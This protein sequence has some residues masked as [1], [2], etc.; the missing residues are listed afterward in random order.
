M[1]ILSNLWHGIQNVRVTIMWRFAIF[2]AFLVIMSIC[3]VAVPVRQEL[4]QN[5]R[6]DA[7][8]DLQKLAKTAADRI[9]TNL[10]NRIKALNGTAT[11]MEF[12]GNDGDPRHM[13]FFKSYAE[14][15]DYIALG[16][17]DKTGKVVAYTTGEPATDLSSRSYIQS[18]LSGKAECSDF[19]TS[20]VTGKF[21]LMIAVPHK[22]GGALI[23][24]VPYEKIYEMVEKIYNYGEGSN[25]FMTNL[26]GVIVAHTDKSLM[27]DGDK[28]T[29][30]SDI[31]H[32]EQDVTSSF[33]SSISKEEGQTFLKGTFNGVTKYYAVARV[34]GKNLTVCVAVTEA[35]LLTSVQSMTRNFI[36]W[37]SIALLVGVL[38]SL[39]AG[40]I[41][42][43]GPK[44]LVEYVKIVMTGKL[45]NNIGKYSNDEI[46]DLA[47]MLN[48]QSRRRM[49][50]IQRLRDLAERHELGYLAERLD[51]EGLQYHILDQSKSVNNLIDSSQK[52][53]QA[54]PVPVLVR[55]PYLTPEE[56]KQSGFKSREVR[57]LN[58]A[59]LLGRVLA[60]VLKKPCSDHFGTEDCLGMC[61]CD[62]A[63]MGQNIRTGS[64]IARPTCLQKPGQPVELNIDYTPNILSIG[65]DGKRVVIEVVKDLTKE[66]GIMKK[67]ADIAVH[68]DTLSIRLG[69][70]SEEL[71]AQADQVL[72]GAG[73]QTAQIQGIATAM[74]QMNTTVFEVAKNASEAAEGA[75]KTKDKAHAGQ[76]CVNEVISSMGDVEGRVGDLRKSM[77]EL[78]ISASAIGKI[79]NT[80]SDIADQTNLLALNAAIEAA[81]AG[82][83]GRGFAVVADEVRKLAEKTMQ[84]TKEVGP[85]IGSIQGGTRLCVENTEK[86]AGAVAKA[87]SF[88]NNAGTSLAEIVDLVD[89]NADQVRN[90]AAAA[91]EQSAASEEI[92]KGV[93]DIN[94][95]SSE[96]TQA[97]N[98]TTQAIGNLARMASELVVVTQELR[99]VSGGK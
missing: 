40:Y 55:G 78:N 63:S 71:S 60:D 30:L 61:A 51:T 46:G 48:E 54:V 59:G 23:A 27:Q 1:K 10:Q 45:D 88:A 75:T 79:M 72:T 33:L 35:S 98:E 4:A 37:G 18:A 15:N 17:V 92:S 22:N 81:R 77:E 64:T 65:E 84:A 25:V 74:E 21:V 86:A 87:T 91:E 82:D 58:E 13:A 85:Q 56:E 47:T 29:S 53:L 57:F 76:D 38:L 31:A 32:F 39:L 3:L 62:E 83:A 11:A 2:A 28:K 7:Q 9:G 6:T 44:H 26:N 89:T 19:I 67:T 20:K 68:G 49:K 95:I 50:T 16:L 73:E 66:R 42:A 8:K 80:I 93:S 69:Q 99:E 52:P 43:K 97:M 24:R 94:R 34:P 90:I 14:T 5:I 70:T 41:F 36:L 12:I 96:T